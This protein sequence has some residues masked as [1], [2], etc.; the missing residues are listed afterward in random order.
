MLGLGRHLFTGTDANHEDGRHEAHEAAKPRRR[1]NAGAF[2]SLQQSDGHDGPPD[3]AADGYAT[4][5]RKP[6]LFFEGL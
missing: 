3:R 5:N 2:I 6:T 1:G 4:A